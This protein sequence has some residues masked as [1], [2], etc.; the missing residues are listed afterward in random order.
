MFVCVRARGRER[1]PVC[2]RILFTTPA[3]FLSPPSSPPPFQNEKFK[4]LL[5]RRQTAECHRKPLTSSLPLHA[6][7]LST[8]LLNPPTPPFLTLNLHRPFLVACVLRMAVQTRQRH[9]L[10]RVCGVTKWLLL[11]TGCGYNRLFLVTQSAVSGP[12]VAVHWLC[13]GSYSLFFALV[14]L[15]LVKH[16]CMHIHVSH[17]ASASIHPIFSCSRFEDAARSRSPVPASG[18]DHSM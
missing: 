5:P 17:I 13:F 8:K 7:P 14:F 9:S 18:S 11:L 15:V 2:L 16:H 4:S 6:L 1:I 12:I 10:D 3:S